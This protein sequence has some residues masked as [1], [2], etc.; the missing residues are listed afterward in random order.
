MVL[1]APYQ[2]TCGKPPLAR[3]AVDLHHFDF[4]SQLPRVTILSYLL[5]RRRQHLWLLPHQA[6]ALLARHA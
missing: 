6:L 1:T 5:V 3:W 4:P 2:A